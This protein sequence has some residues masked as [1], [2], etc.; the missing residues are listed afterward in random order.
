MLRCYGVTQCYTVLRYQVSGLRS[1]LQRRTFFMSQCTYFATSTLNS[2]MNDTLRRFDVQRPHGALYRDL[3]HIHVAHCGRFKAQDVTIR[4]GGAG[5]SLRGALG[6]ESRWRECGGESKNMNS[7]ASHNIPHIAH[8]Q[9]TT[10]YNRTQ[11]HIAHSTPHAANQEK[12]LLSL[13]PL[14]SP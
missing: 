14:P 13:L 2:S 6:H 12:I 4:V 3:R 10:A 7:Y 8:K 11:P 1:Q 5:G 9:H